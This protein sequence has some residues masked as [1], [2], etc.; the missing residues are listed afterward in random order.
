[1]KRSL[2]LALWSTG[3]LGGPCK[4]SKPSETSI[5][6]GTP[7]QSNHISLGLS[8]TYGDS[9]K[10]GQDSAHDTSTGTSPHESGQISVS[11]PF[12]ESDLNTNTQDAVSNTIGLPEGS[13]TGTGS[14]PEPTSEGGSVPGTV[15]DDGDSEETSGGAGNSGS[16]SSPQT[17]GSFPTGTADFPGE[18]S[19]TVT[20][21][22]ASGTATGPEDSGNP[23]G[24]ASGFP[25]Q[26]SGTLVN[27]EVS[28]QPTGTADV[29]GGPGA[30]DANTATDLPTTIPSDVP[31]GASDTA[32]NPEG[33]GPSGTA[34]GPG[35]AGTTASGGVPGEASG[36]S[37]Q[38][39]GASDTATIPEGS[40]PSGT[41]TVPGEPGTTD[42]PTGISEGVSDSSSGTATVPGEADNTASGGVPGDAS[43]TSPPG[44]DANPTEVATDGTSNGGPTV[45][46]D[47]TNTPGS[48]EETVSN[49]AT[50]TEQG[51]DTA[52]QTDA[53]P[54]TEVAPT[55]IDTSIAGPATTAPG[56]TLPNDQGTLTQSNGDEFTS[57]APGDATED[58]SG[59]VTTDANGAPTTLPG[60]QDQ[61]TGSPE[62]STSASSDQNSDGNSNE[63]SLGQEDSSAASTTDGNAA[64]PTTEGDG[65]TTKPVADNTDASSTG[66][67]EVNNGA[68]TTGSGPVETT[69]FDG[70]PSTTV[71]APSATANPVT[72]AA[73]TDTDMPVVTEA[74]P[75]FNPSTVIGHP[76]WTTNTWITTTT[77]EGSDPTVV[78]VLVGCNDCGGGGSGII[79]WGFPPVINTWFQLPN[80]PKFSFPCIPPASGCTSTPV[81]EETGEDGDDDDDDDDKSST[82][83]TDKATV[84][85]CF[86]ACTT[87]T[88]PAGVSVTPECQTTCTKTH[89]GCSVTGT[90]TTSSAAACGPSGDSECTTCNVDLTAN[91]DSESLKRRSL[92][93]RGGIDIKKNIAGCDWSNTP[94]GAPRFPAYPGGNLVLN[95]EAAIVSQNSPLNQ[96]KRWWRTTRDTNCVPSLNNIGEASYPKT[97]L[98]DVEG[99]S[100][101]HVYE[102]SMLLDFWR[103]IIDPAAAAVVGMKTG[104]PNKINC[105]DIKSY[106][107]INSGSNLIQ[108]VF[109]T[110]PGS[111]EVLMPNNAQFMDDFIG[112]DQ[113]TNGNA[114]AQITD[115]QG[116]KT[117]ADKKASNG[118]AVRA[119]TNIANAK[120]WI[121]DKMLFLE[122]LAIGVEMF[123][124]DEAKNALIRQNLRIYQTLVDMDENAKNCMKDDAVINGVWSFADKYQTFMADRF[125]GNQD[126]SMNQGVVYAKNKLITALTT[127]VANAANIANIPAGDLTSWQ[128]RLANMQDASRVWEVSVTFVWAGPT[129][130]KRDTDGLSCDR[131]NPSF[132]T[133][134]TVEPTTDFTTFATSMRPSSDIV[135]S[136][137]V[138]ST[139]EQVT[140]S[141]N[142][143]LLTDL[144]SLTQQVPD[145]TISTPD[146]SSCAETATVTNCNVGIGGGHGGPACVERETCNSWIN[147]KTTSTTPSPTPTL[148]KPDPGLNEKHCYNSGQQSNYEAITYAAESFCRDVVND[149]VQGPVWSNYK[150]EGKKTPSTGYHFKLAFQ[151]NEGCVWTANYDECMRYMKV[152]ID[153]CNCSAKGNKQG[154]WVENNCIMARIDPNSGT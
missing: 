37:P 60:N 18:H 139:T 74:P 3:V 58:H 32:T 23:S 148:A 6:D 65:V 132:T 41:A 38:D 99:P 64:Q 12:S 39:S 153:S 144:P 69:D 143:P 98:T 102:K 118:K 117:Q 136:D 30:T 125:T 40:G 106:G 109:D 21:P 2:L 113:W 135:T 116:T 17:D 35:E 140:S 107:G 54:S 95:N 123:N 146:G 76:E 16:P 31:G 84:T 47:P 93:R 46:H 70:V 83:C 78:P 36:T 104:T 134:S 92:E 87:Y 1:M 43:G 122:A 80:L 42:S 29:P 126:Y 56:N 89:T 88:G 66:S 9:T 24:T 112:M 33:S 11:I 82:T 50:G 124:V 142:P 137:E 48:P 105:D 15:T 128:K 51:Q 111:A 13:V 147:T 154:G 141:K 152:P 145:T 52:T 27:T 150:L 72:S 130:S 20:N 96:I 97:G 133:E 85:D 25:E 5:A 61:T 53:A 28:G 94:V 100:I 22:D 71:P 119:N 149:Q 59:A 75:G 151:V 108:K 90:T 101:D 127:D 63:T 129:T 79:L 44:S 103:F 26:S 110:Y 49:P 114:K 131:P 115:P 81:T 7:T 138:P 19:G 45:S 86:V 67:S 10:T 14:F 34:T 68:T 57:A 77:S 62:Q 91:D 73:T 8:S 120:R 121:E 4:P 55:G